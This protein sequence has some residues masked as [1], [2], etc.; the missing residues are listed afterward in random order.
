MKIINLE[1]CDYI[2]SNKILRAIERAEFES[3]LGR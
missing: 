3:T 2:D 1:N